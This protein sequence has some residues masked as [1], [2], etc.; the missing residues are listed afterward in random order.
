MEE[1]ICIVDAIDLNCDWTSGGAVADGEAIDENNDCW[2]KSPPISQ[3]MPSPIRKTNIIRA[4]FF[5][6]SSAID[7]TNVITDKARN[8]QKINRILA[9]IKLAIGGMSCFAPAAFIAACIWSTGNMVL[10]I[11]LWAMDISIVN[12]LKTINTQARTE[13]NA[14]RA[15][16]VSLDDLS[17]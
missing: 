2:K 12:P 4:Q 14:E 5:R 10:I 6:L 7:E 9:I 8:V 16:W 3:T 11:I 13:I 1:K 15:S 17:T